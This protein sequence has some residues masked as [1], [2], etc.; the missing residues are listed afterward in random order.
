M[1]RGVDVV[2]PDDHT[3]HV[4]EVVGI[5]LHDPGAKLAEPSDTGWSIGRQPASPTL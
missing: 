2:A 5:E 1:A 3:I 4:A